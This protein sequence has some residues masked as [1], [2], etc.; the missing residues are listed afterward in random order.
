MKAKNVGKLAMVVAAGTALVAALIN[1]NRE[2]LKDELNDGEE[3][4]Q[5]E[6]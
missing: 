5:E 4:E 1:D 3:I 2:K 6:N